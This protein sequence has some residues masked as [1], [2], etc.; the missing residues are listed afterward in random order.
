MAYTLI[1]VK[2]L[3]SKHNQAVRIKNLW[4]MKKIDLLKVIRD[5]GLQIVETNNKVELRPITRP[6]TKIQKIFKENVRS[7]RART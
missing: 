2:R 7:R 6:R 1:Q 3:M 5:N 4:K